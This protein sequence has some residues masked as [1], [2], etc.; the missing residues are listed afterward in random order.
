MNNQFDH[1]AEIF[2]ALGMTPET[3]PWAYWVDSDIGK[4]RLVEYPYGVDEA[5]SL[6]DNTYIY[7]ISLLSDSL[8]ADGLAVRLVRLTNKFPVYLRKTK[9]YRVVYGK[10]NTSYIER[11]SLAHAVHDALVD[12]L[13]ITSVRQMPKEERK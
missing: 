2:A 8:E 1:T 3:H 5:L 13:G 6:C 12:A 9:R 11:D 4:Y 7:V 10:Y